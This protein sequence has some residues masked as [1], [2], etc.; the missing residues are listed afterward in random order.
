MWWYRQQ[1]NSLQSQI[2]KD[3]EAESGHSLAIH[4]EMRLVITFSL[5][6]F[7]SRSWFLVTIKY[8]VWSYITHENAE[9]SH[10]TKEWIIINCLWRLGSNR[11]QLKWRFG[12]HGNWTNQNPGA[13]LKLPA[14]HDCQFSPLSPMLGKWVGYWQCFLA[15]S[16][17]TGFNFFQLP[18]VPIIHLKWKTLRSGCPHF[19]NIIIHI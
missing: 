7:T 1:K 5:H 18:W 2:K 16:S 8:K 3:I 10:T 15:G 12:I 9:A 19:S 13:I 11:F 14:K 17:K 6:F 4:Q